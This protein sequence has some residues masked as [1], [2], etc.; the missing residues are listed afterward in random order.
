ME[1]SLR[2][3]RDA[4]PCA[5][6]GDFIPPSAG[7][8]CSVLQHMSFSYDVRRI[9]LYYLGA[10]RTLNMFELCV[11]HPRYAHIQVH[12]RTPLQSSYMGIIRLTTV[13]DSV[14]SK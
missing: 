1:S 9:F 10:L 6:S 14:R 13:A 3:V 12:V 4:V 5:V 8:L 7:A 2:V 11:V